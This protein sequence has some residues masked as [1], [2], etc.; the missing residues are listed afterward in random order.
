MF[1]KH[2]ALAFAAISVITAANAAEEIRDGD[3][4]QKAVFSPGE[5]LNRK[6]TV[7]GTTNWKIDAIRDKTG[8]MFQ[9]VQIASNPYIQAVF[10]CVNV[11]NERIEPK[12]QYTFDASYLETQLLPPTPGIAGQFKDV[13]FAC[14]NFR[15]NAAPE[16][17]SPVSPKAGRT[18]ETGVSG[19]LVTASLCDSGE[20]VVFACNTGKKSVSVCSSS[21][22][23]QYRFGLDRNT[24]D[25]SLDAKG[26]GAGEYPLAGGG[27]WYYRFNNGSTN[28]VVYTAESSSMDKAGLVVEQGGKRTA[29]LTCKNAATVNAKLAGAPTDTKGFEVP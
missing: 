27:V 17:Q 9:K 16:Q 11:N 26:A 6:F 21:K 1:K 5:L 7:K 12:K 13:L 28:Y 10:Y 22:G 25:I 19:A 18:I 20:G 8:T 29:S 2:Y 14:G 4:L 3:L 15:S 24:L 23:L